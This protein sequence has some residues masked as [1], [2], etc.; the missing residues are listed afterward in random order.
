M[1][2]EVELDKE[3]MIQSSEHIFLSTHIR[4][5]LLTD[6][7][8]LVKYLHCKGKFQPH[9]ISLVH[10]KYYDYMELNY[11]MYITSAALKTELGSNGAFPGTT[12]TTLST[13]IILLSTR[14]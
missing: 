9:N 11:C 3:G 4:Y 2:G 7:M 13:S 5:L 1:E 6:D 12:D 8:S 10:N 14:F